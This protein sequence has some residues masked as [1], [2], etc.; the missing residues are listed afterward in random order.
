MWTDL[1]ARYANPA[2]ACVELGEFARQ[3]RSF[4]DAR[5]Q[6]V[7]DNIEGADDICHYYR[8]LY[9]VSRLSAP[10]VSVETGTRLGCSALQIA[11]GNPGGIVITVDVDPAAALRVADL[12]AKNILPITGDSSKVFEKVKGMV[13]EIDLLY[14]D[15]DHSFKTAMSEYTLYGSLV[16]KGG[17]MLFDDITIN[18]EMKSFWMKVDGPK[19]ELPHLH[20]GFSFGCA[21][22]R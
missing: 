10:S 1:S 18:D 7:R 17:V 22:K 19:V 6:W 15:S 11:V 2:A 9:E 20:T 21:I 5:P 3:L 16:R 13:T 14:I 12:N 8:F 4:E